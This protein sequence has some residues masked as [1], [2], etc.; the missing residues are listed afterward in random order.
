MTQLI[1]K[2]SGYKSYAVAVVTV[3]YAVVIVGGQH[4][5]WNNA[6]QLILGA[7]GLGALRHGM[8]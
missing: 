7:L 3:L 6:T 8:K 5:D 1:Q 4:G 2:L